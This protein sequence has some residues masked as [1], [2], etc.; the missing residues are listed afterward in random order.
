MW[1]IFVAVAGAQSMPK[2]PSGIAWQVK[3]LWRLDGGANPIQT[4]DTIK[5]GSLLWPIE[6]SPEHSVT[7]LLPDGQRILY[8]CFLAADCSRGFR[9]PPLYRK[10]DPQAA[11]VL[12]RIHAVLATPSREPEVALRNGGPLP[13]DE[14][15]TVLDAQSEAKSPAW[16]RL[17]PMDITRIRCAVSAILIRRAFAKHSRKRGVRDLSDIPSP[18]LYDVIVTDSLNTPRVD[19][20]I[21]AVKQPKAA[22]LQASFRDA[23]VLLKDWND[24]FQGWPIHDFQRAYL[25][26]FRFWAS[27]LKSRAHSPSLRTSKGA[28]REWLQ[29]PSLFPAP[30]CCEVIPP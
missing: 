4:G 8:E 11:G 16:C 24:D 12:W 15:V 3:G 10:P 23:K 6:G 13:R 18:G 1:I 19:L 21:A 7:V 27:T 9:V 25:E 28:V 26:A 2:S 29:N 22:N 20:L 5:P 30:E 17:S 14:A